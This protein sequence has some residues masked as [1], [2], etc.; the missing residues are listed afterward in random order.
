MPLSLRLT[1]F[2]TVAPLLAASSN[3]RA[4]TLVIASNPPGATVEIDGVAVGKT[5]LTKDYPGGYFHRPRTILNPRLERPLVARLTLPGYAT[6]EIPL[7]EGPLEWKT[8]LRGTKRFDFWL[9]KAR[10]FDTQLE[11]IVK[12][13][14]GS[15]NSAVPTGERP[16]LS[17]IQINL[18][19]KD[20]VV[21]LKSSQKM[22]SGF[23][24]TSTGLIATNKHLAEGQE[25]LRITLAS[26]Q[27]MD[28]SVVYLDPELDIALVKAPE[29]DFRALSLASLETVRQG[30]A[31][32]AVGN[33]A[34]AMAFSM[35]KGIV[36]AV[37]KFP[38]AG[39]GTWIQTDAPIN[40]GNSGGPL[41][42]QTGEVVAMSTQK[43]VKKNVNGIAFALS[44]DDLLR[45]LHRF[46]PAGVPTLP[47][48]DDQTPDLQKMAAPP[49]KETAVRSA[50]PSSDARN[51]QL[52]VRGTPG[53]RIFV[54][55]TVVGDIPA[56]ISLKQGRHKLHVYKSGF[57]DL[58][59][60]VYVTA[61]STVT[62]DAE[63][64]A[65][66]LTNQP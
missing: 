30:D 26:G 57:V 40:P 6:R 59:R 50:A 24:V 39:P 65:I 47:P 49:V 19:T 10:R 11:S 63:L 32:L 22:G 53:A 25:S 16:A 37:G 58:V 54:D 56:T 38:N 9:F 28:G 12:I 17:D 46:Y 31:V 27:Q 1:V 51:G 60:I 36:S 61:E 48:S 5:P 55:K 62:I 45:V 29:G 33:P 14:T 52:E 7:T 41:I 8:T 64:E 44:A 2:L 35:T 4:D 21:Q 20:A 23:F 18:L 15:I 66:A 43:L 42:N 3:V 34:D 13:F